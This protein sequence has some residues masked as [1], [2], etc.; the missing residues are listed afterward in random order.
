MARFLAGAFFFLAAATLPAAPEAF[1][2]RAPVAFL[3]PLAAAF[4]FAGVFF[5]VSVFFLARISS[6]SGLSRSYRALCA[7]PND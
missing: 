4:F 2:L 7:H 3:V 1:A 5:F 6:S